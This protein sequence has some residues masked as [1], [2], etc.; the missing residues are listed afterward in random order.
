MEN[1]GINPSGGPGGDQQG[2]TKEEFNKLVDQNKK[3]IDLLNN[4]VDAVGTQN[5]R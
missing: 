3:I 5:R 1:A 4:L 2:V